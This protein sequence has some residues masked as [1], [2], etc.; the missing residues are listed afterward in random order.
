MKL[1]NNKGFSLIEL[2]VVVAIIGILAAVG[3]PQYSKFQA[4]ARQGE[5]KSTLAAM[6]T[7]ETSFFIEWNQYSADL[8]A[9]GMAVSGTNLRYTAGFNA[10]C[11]TAAPAPVEVAAAANAQV[12][13][14]NVNNGGTPATFLA[15]TG[16]AAGANVV[17]NG[18]PACVPGTSFTA[19]ATGDPRQNAAVISGTSDTWTIT[20]AKT[21][22]NPVAGL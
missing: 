7:A 5:A 11:G 22:A 1:N 4:K 21:L 13:R 19:S 9:V 12:H 10:N 14:T 17:L 6:Y 16:I 8:R 15:A 3:V 20:N 18:T 2:M